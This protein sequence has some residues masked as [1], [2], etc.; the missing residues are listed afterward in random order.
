VTS[1][2]RREAAG[3]SQASRGGPHRDLLAT[4]VAAAARAADP[5]R[6]K[7]GT[8]SSIEWREKS[9]TDFVSE[10]DLAAEAIARDVIRARHPEALV[11]GEESSPETVL[12]AELAFVVDP[13][14]G[15]TNFLHGYPEYAV[16]IAAVRMGVPLAGAVLNVPTGELFTATAGGGARRNGE[17]IAVSR[18]DVP[19]RA[20]VGTGFP[21]KR[22]EEI[23]PYL[24]QMAR[25]IRG[26]SGIRRAGAA[27]LDLAD[28]ACGRFEAFWELTLAPW[29]IAAG[30]LLVR[31]AGGRATDLG[32]R[33]APIAH[34]PVVA[35]NPAMHAWLLEQLTTATGQ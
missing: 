5:I 32:G 33:D 28:V 12:G 31:E 25:V 16:S 1:D 8:R 11:L 2:Q 34:G 4:C 24:A 18:I 9:P 14:D 29:D 21:F 3:A 15:T 10:V 19:A 20:L 13:L 6:A 30:I 35:G 22:I 26:T 17:A 23:E 27:A 7:A